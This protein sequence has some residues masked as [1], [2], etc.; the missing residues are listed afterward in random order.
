MTVIQIFFG[1]AKVSLLV[2]L[3]LAT[4]A[5]HPASAKAPIAIADVAALAKALRAIDFLIPHH[6]LAR[7]DAVPRTRITGP[8]KAVDWRE[9][10]PFQQSIYL[11][12]VLSAVL[13]DKEALLPSAR[14]CRA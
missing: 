8:G 4:N 10:V 1:I 6:H 5:W 14:S 2:S 12:R 7:L 3:V 11:R 9:K 13:Q